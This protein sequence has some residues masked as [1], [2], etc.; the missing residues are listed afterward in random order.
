M[1]RLRDFIR[2]LSLAKYSLSHAAL[3]KA[4]DLWLLRLPRAPLQT[5]W[6]PVRI[7]RQRGMSLSV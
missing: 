3:K 4:P 2:D 5:L 7:A 6:D 1:R